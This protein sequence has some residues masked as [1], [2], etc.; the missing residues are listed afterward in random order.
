MDHAT[1]AEW[2]LE[3]LVVFAPDPDPVVVSDNLNV[4]GFL[5]KLDRIRKRTQPIAY[6]L[7]GAPGYEARFL[8]H[9]VAQ[10]VK[11][12]AA[13]CH[14]GTDVKNTADDDEL[15]ETAKPAGPAT[16]YSHPPAVDY[17]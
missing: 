4:L 6:L 15:H 2:K 13:L 14:L 16:A 3:L 8:K 12:H 9:R 7:I 17:H 5:G 1:L 10:P 11:R